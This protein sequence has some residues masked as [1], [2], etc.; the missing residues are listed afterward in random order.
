MKCAFIPSFLPLSFPFF[1]P[2]QA[3]HD[4]GHCDQHPQQ[5]QD[6]D[7]DL[8]LPRY[9]SSSP[10]PLP[11]LPRA[12]FPSFQLSRSPC[13]PSPSLPSS[14]PLS[15]PPYPG[16]RS[17]GADA[18]SLL[19]RRPEVTYARIPTL[20]GRHDEHP[21]V[22]L[23]EEAYFPTKVRLLH[24]TPSFLP[25]R[26]PCLFALYPPGPARRASFHGPVGRGTR[27]GLLSLTRWHGTALLPLPLLCVCASA[28]PSSLFPYL[29]HPLSN[30]PFPSFLLPSTLP[31]TRAPISSPLS[32][33]LT[34]SLPPSSLLRSPTMRARAGCPSSTRTRPLTPPRS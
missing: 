15:V 10:S 6:R 34:L 23:L 18:Y 5:A 12:S 7:H 24:R 17:Y 31:S 13:P 33:S 32:P 29:V 11:S 3:R 2:G 9:A 14:L 21:S 30:Y 8:L 25:S 20:L 22:A 1:L 4:D 19:T 27:R 26:F 16:E 28:C